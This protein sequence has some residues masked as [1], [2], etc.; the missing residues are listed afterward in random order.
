MVVIGEGLPVKG[1]ARGYPIRI[2]VYLRSTGMR[3]ASILRWPATIRRSGG[4]VVETL[5]VMGLRDGRPLTLFGEAVLPPGEYEVTLHDP[6]DGTRF[7]V[8]SGGGPPVYLCSHDC[9][10]TEILTRSIPDGKGRVWYGGQDMVIWPCCQDVIR[11]WETPESYALA[12]YLPLNGRIHVKVNERSWVV[13]AG[14][15]LALNPLDPV[16][17]SARQ[18]WP[19]HLRTVIV[20]Q[21]ALRAFRESVGLR[22]EDGPFRLAPGPR[23]LVGKVAS[24]V[25]EWVGSWQTRSAI[26]YEEYVGLATRRLLLELINHH[27]NTFQERVAQEGSLRHV[28]VRIRAALAILTQQYHRPLTIEIVAREIGV[29]GAWLRSQFLRDMRQGFGEYLRGWRMQQ[30]KGLLKNPTLSVEEVAHAV[31]YRD[32]RAFRRVFRAYTHASPRHI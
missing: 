6:T 20:E 27:P 29:G 16:R 15:Y 10:R 14:E 28:D 9:H 31:G 11:A 18:R 22:K 21:A 25:E 17:L 8:L 24:A 19:L 4:E 30:A 7:R 13:R 2:H 23:P 3:E 12:L 5:E 32:V 1:P 26:G